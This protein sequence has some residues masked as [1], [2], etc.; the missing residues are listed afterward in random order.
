MKKIMVA[1]TEPKIVD[2]GVSICP[3]VYN[4]LIKMR[5]YFKI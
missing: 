1:K 4:D 2:F 3:M 5:T